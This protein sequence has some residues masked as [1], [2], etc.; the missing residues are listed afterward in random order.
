MS[1]ASWTPTINAPAAS[2]SK[3]KVL[4]DLQAAATTYND[5]TV[6]YNSSVTYY[7]GYNPTGTTP[8]GES[9]AVWTAVAE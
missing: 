8:E 3:N 2:W 4:S 6:T 1:S 5:P 7:N 9:G